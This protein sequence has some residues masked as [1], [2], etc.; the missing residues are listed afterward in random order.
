VKIT[1]EMAKEILKA[2]RLCFNANHGPYG[3]HYKLLI[4]G[5]HVNFPQIVESD[6]VKA[7]DCM[8]LNKSKVRTADANS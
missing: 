8:L 5:I 4:A 1:T 2:E 6:D 3:Y 7:L